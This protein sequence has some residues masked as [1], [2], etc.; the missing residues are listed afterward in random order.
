VKELLTWQRFG[1]LSMLNNISKRFPTIV[2]DIYESLPHVEN[3]I[4][5]THNRPAENLIAH[6]DNRFS[7]HKLTS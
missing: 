6:V 5:V 4:K 7:A 2:R 1:T 3:T